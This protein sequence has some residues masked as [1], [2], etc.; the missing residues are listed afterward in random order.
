MSFSPSL[1]GLSSVLFVRCSFSDS[2]RHRLLL[3]PLEVGRHADQPKRHKSEGQRQ[4]VHPK[5]GQHDMDGQGDRA[6]HKKRIA[7]ER[8]DCCPEGFQ[9]CRADPAHIT[10]QQL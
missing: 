8:S 4:S 5:K 9:L 3:L 7:Q 1:S 2:P 6:P 10:E